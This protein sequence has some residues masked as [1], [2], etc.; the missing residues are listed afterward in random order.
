MTMGF[1]KDDLLH[2][3][4]CTI[5]LVVYWVT[6]GCFLGSIYALVHAMFF[7]FI[8]GLVVTFIFLIISI[9][10]AGSTEYCGGK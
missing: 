6:I 3:I 10:L 1:L 4:I 2:F 9:I 7:G 8:I 5:K